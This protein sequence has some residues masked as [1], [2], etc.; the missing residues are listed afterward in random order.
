MQV[1]ASIRAPSGTNQ[2]P[3]GVSASGYAIAGPLIS[4]LS[5]LAPKE[6]Y[7][8]IAEE[9]RR[10]DVDTFLIGLEDVEKSIAEGE[11]GFLREQSRCD[12]SGIADTIAELG[13]WAAFR[14]EPPKREPTPPPLPPLP[15]LAPPSDAFVPPPPKLSS[16][17]VGR[18]ELCPCGSGKKFKKCCGARRG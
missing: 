3:S 1:I 13:T 14:P 2:G 10:D 17:R 12:P 9:Y 5:C 18:N 7:E 16:Q 11:A 15:R 4:V 8:D 6:A